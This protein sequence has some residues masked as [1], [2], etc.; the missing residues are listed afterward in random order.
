MPKKLKRFEEVL[1]NKN[2]VNFLLDHIQRGTLPTRIIFEGEEGLGKTSLAKLIA[3]GVNCSGSTKPCYNCPSCRQI[4]NDV[5]ENNKD[6]DSVKVYNMS[7]DSGKD[8]A[9]EV[10]ANLSATM[11]STG[12]RVVICDEAHGMSD[13]AQDVF[14]VDM[15]YLPKN[16]YIIFCTTNAENL[17]K[18][19]KSR[20]FTIRLHRPK[21]KEI[22]AMLAEVATRNELTVQGGPATLSLIADW[23]ECKPRK[24]INLLE[25]F[26]TNRPVSTEMIKEFIDYVEVDEIIPILDALSGS[27][28]AGLAYAQEMRLNP[29]IIDLLSD[30]LT[31]KLGGACYKFSADDLRKLRAYLQNVTEE[32]LITFLREVTR[33]PTLTRSAVV[34]ALL[35]A[36]PLGEKI[37][38]QDATVLQNELMQKSEVPTTTTARATVQQTAPTF[39]QLL[40]GAKQIRGDNQ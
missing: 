38:K 8:A 27:L 2:T 20:A 36:H 14:L 21:K 25:G 40:R 26:G 39:D 31:I 17:K 3:M 6:T 16:T 18:T 4:M 5:I 29:T 19:L 11:S 33:F 34:S 1:G 24:A 10:K 28:T 9:K 35:A 37:D 32:A 22:V 13:A 15:E 23:A 30:A 7:V 12:K